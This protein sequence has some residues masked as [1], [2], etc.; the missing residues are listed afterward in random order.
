MADSAEGRGAIDEAAGSTSASEDEDGGEEEGDGEIDDSTQ[1][2]SPRVYTKEEMERKIFGEEGEEEDPAFRDVDGTVPAA[3]VHPGEHKVADASAIDEE[4][5]GESEGEVEAESKS[6]GPFGPPSNTIS[7]SDVHPRS[8]QEDEADENASV[9]EGTLEVAAE[10]AAE[11]AAVDALDGVNSSENGTLSTTTTSPLPAPSRRPL[12]PSTSSLSAQP[13]SPLPE[14][15]FRARSTNDKAPTRDSSAE[16]DTRVSG[17]PPDVITVPCAQ[18]PAPEE[19]EPCK[20]VVVAKSEE[21]PTCSMI[22]RMVRMKRLP[23]FSPTR[24]GIFSGPTS[25][26]PGNIPL[27]KRKRGGDDDGDETKM[28][29]GG[30]SDPLRDREGLLPR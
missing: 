14:R 30:S 4:S 20:P 6:D 12:N 2:D 28:A 23:N 21:E 11:P 7:T 18:A 13:P 24:P 1:E 19:V 10:P 8:Q 5:D 9:V 26:S 29:S 15:G 16:A 17:L 22:R 27:G 25:D 3:V